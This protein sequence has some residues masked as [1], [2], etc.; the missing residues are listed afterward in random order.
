M[1]AHQRIN[2]LHILQEDR[3]ISKTCNQLSGCQPRK[4]GAFAQGG[5]GS[6]QRGDGQ[7]GAD[8]HPLLTFGAVG[9]DF[10]DDLSAATLVGQGFAQPEVEDF[11]VGWRGSA[12]FDSVE[13]VLGFA[14]VLLPQASTSAADPGPL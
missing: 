9:I 8:T 6:V 5:D 2:L 3:S 11:G 12:A 14:K 13:D 4:D 7:I 10:V 1:G